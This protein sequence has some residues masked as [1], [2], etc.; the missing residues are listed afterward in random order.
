MIVACQQHAAPA[1][2]PG[3]LTSVS[4]PSCRPVGA[5]PGREPVRFEN[6]QLGR[7][8][9]VDDSL[10]D[11]DAKLSLTDLKPGALQHGAL[12]LIR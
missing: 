4:K 6:P 11:H 10:I 8:E 2:K 12:Q 9:G 3:S 7:E 5:G 1:S